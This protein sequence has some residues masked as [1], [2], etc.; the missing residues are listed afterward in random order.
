MY[1]T[2][3]LISTLLTQYISNYAAG[4]RPGR[5]RLVDTPVIAHLNPI[6]GQGNVKT[7]FLYQIKVINSQR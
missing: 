5:Y 6:T 1:Y 7:C 2:Y 4:L 3:I